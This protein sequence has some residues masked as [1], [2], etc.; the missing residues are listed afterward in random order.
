MKYII[1]WTTLIFLLSAG[2]F[3]TYLGA[4]QEAPEAESVTVKGQVTF[5]GTVQKCLFV[6]KDVRVMTDRV[7]ALN[8]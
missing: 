1:Y 8:F 7:S 4:Y 5:K 2:A 6:V 3:P